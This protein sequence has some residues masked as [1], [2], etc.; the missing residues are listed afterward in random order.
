MDQERIVGKIT[1]PFEVTGKALLKMLYLIGK[2]WHDKRVWKLE[3]PELSKKFMGEQKWFDLLNSKASHNMQT[4]LNSE[5]NFDKVNEQFKDLGIVFS[6][7]ENSDGT[8]DIAWLSRDDKIAEAAIQKA[9][10]QIVDDPEKFLSKV[11]KDDKHAKPK[12][13]I[14]HFKKINIDELNRLK[15]TIGKTKPIGRS[16]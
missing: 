8:T 3:H 6:T 7:K 10:K 9:M 2:L 1:T 12:D 14:K 11:K 16:K 5:V 13:Q 15:E 4:F